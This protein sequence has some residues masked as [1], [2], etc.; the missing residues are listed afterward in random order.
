M[1]RWS[2]IIF[3]A[4]VSIVV[5]EF[6]FSFQ[7]NKYDTT[8]YTAQSKNYQKSGALTSGPYVVTI[9]HWLNEFHE[10]IIA[11]S[12]FGIFIVTTGLVVY[13]AFLWNATNT[14]VKGNKDT[15]RKELR[16]YIALDRL[17]FVRNVLKVIAKNHGRTPAHKMSIW[18]RGLTQDD[19]VTALD[20]AYTDNDRNVS[21]QM[22]HPEQSF[23]TAVLLDIP[24]NSVT[25]GCRIY[26]RF[27]YQDI[28][29]RW[30]VTMFCHRYEGE[31]RFVP[32]GEY[33]KEDGPYDYRPS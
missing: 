8:H 4:L 21:E 12:T 3:I 33:N 20:Q 9:G 28:Y 23:S 13:T 32:E 25:E 19:A 11:A 26:G 14:L 15:A 17:L 10:E 7:I 5:I 16:A 1:K 6:G 29:D 30:W 24:Y 27:I 2:I 31:N 22:L 18:T